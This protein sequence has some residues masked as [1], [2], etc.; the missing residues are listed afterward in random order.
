MVLRRPLRA[1]VL[2]L[3]ACA[4]SGCG[5]PDARPELPP[6]TAPDSSETGKQFS[7]SVPDSTAAPFLGIELYYRLAGVGSP[8]A[9]PEPES[10]GDL[11][12]RGFLRIASDTDRYPSPQL[13]LIAQPHAGDRVIVD[14]GRVSETYGG[15][16]F[17]L[18]GGVS[19]SLRRAV[20]DAG[21]AEY[22]RF[23]C[24]EFAGD[25]ADI[26]LVQD[27]LADTEDCELVQLQLYALSYGR[28]DAFPVYSEPVELGSINLQFERR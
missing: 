11:L 2:A 15:E 3:A 19:L 10:R 22:K 5:L 4:I 24:D 9:R 27:Q 20:S 17:V 28:T 14:F 12:S 7:F 26:D 6:P 21:N 18:A 25:D 8:P 23:A 13:P 1:A 16:P